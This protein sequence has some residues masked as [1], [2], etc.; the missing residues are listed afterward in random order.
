MGYNDSFSTFLIYLFCKYYNIP[1]LQERNEYP[2]LGMKKNIFKR[3]DIHIYLTFIC[4]SFDGMLLITNNLLEY[5]A[6]KV[7]KSAKLILVPITVEPERFNCSKK[8]FSEKYIAYCG[9]MGGNKDGIPILI[10]AFASIL[11]KHDNLKLY[12]IGDTKTPQEMDKLKQKVIDLN[13]FDKVVF[14]GRIA[15]DEMPRYLCNATILALA[16]PTSIQ[17]QGGFPTKLGEYLSTGNP[18]VVTKV[19]EIPDYLTDGVNAYLSEPDSVEAFAEKLEIALSNPEVSKK[20]GLAGKEL[21][22]DVF[23]YKTQGQRILNFIEKIKND[24]VNISG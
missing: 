19:G 18:V 8:D 6:Q 14:T 9:H 21:A 2:F 10:E 7:N 1:I 5:F 24:K 17:A 12:L 15:R 22:L 16:R 4:K 20:I 23:S 11:D 3:V 13:V